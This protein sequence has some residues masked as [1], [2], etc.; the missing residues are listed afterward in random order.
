[1]SATTAEDTLIAFLKTS[2]LFSNNSLQFIS[3]FT[4]YDLNLTVFKN[5]ENQTSYLPG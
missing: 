2:F 1:M 5:T 3:H 4:I